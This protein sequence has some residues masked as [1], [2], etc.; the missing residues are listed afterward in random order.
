[1]LFF[2]NKK[3]FLQQALLI[4]VIHQHANAMEVL[5]SESVLPSH[6]ILNTNQLNPVPQIDFDAFDIDKMREILRKWG[7]FELVGPTVD[8][9]KILVERAMETNKEILTLPT[10]CLEQVS[11]DDELNKRETVK[12][13]YQNLR[14][15]T[16]KNR[17]EAEIKGND[18][19]TV[20][21]QNQIAYIYNPYLETILPLTQSKIP[22]KP[23][24]Q[25]MNM[26]AIDDF[27]AEGGR[28]IRELYNK[29]ALSFIKEDKRSQ[30][31][32]G[33]QLPLTIRRYFKTTEGDD[34]E[35]GICEHFDFG[36][37]AIAISDQPGLEIQSEG[38]WIQAPC[39]PLYRIHINIGKW[40][41]LQTE[42]DD[43][44][45]AGFHRVSKVATER[46]FIGLNL[47]PPFEEK[48]VMPNGEQLSFYEYIFGTAESSGSLDKF[49]GTVTKS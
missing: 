16:L 17:R 31:I 3:V 30:F 20:L 44:F 42:L 19:S 47:F 8:H 24:G 37:L 29:I 46:Y 27:Y 18:P 21:I 11:E 49:E 4:F 48:I 28:I 12:H 22:M 1:M 14:D 7:N 35:V 38:R 9:F 34:G 32:H 26:S 36:L 40:L 13:G 5:E 2:T 15:V 25:R 41:E 39:N 45:T 33:K 23:D 6:Q 10:E 43:H